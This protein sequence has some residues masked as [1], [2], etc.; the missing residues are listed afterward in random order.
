MKSLSDKKSIIEALD[1][2][3]VFLE[4][5]GENPFKVRAFSNASRALQSSTEDINKLVETDRIIEIK[6]IGKGIADVITEL[7]KTGRSSDLERLKASVPSG[8]IEMLRLPGIGPKKAKALWEKLGISSVGEL[9]YACME[10]RLLDLDGFGKKTQDKILLGIEMLKKYSERHLLSE[11][12]MEAETLFGSIKD[13]PGVIRGQIAGSIRRYMETVK[14][15]DILISAK[16]EDRD[17]IMDKFVSLPQVEVLIAKGNTKS[18]VTLKGGMNADLRIV[19]DQEFPYALHHFTGSKEHNVAMRGYARKG[20][21]KMNEY[22]LFKG[23]SENIECLSESD[24]FD[25]LNMQYIPPELRENYGEIELAQERAIPRLIDIKDIR[26]IIHVHSNYSDGV[27]T[28]SELAKAAQQMGYH[29]LAITDHSR[30]AAYANGLTEERILRQHEEIDRINTE[31]KTFRVLKGIECDIIADGTLD[32]KDHVLASFDL[33]IASVHYKLNMTEGEATG[34]VLAAMQNPYVTILGHPTGRLL[35]ARE[36]YP[37]DMHRVIQSAA[38]LG[39]SIELNSNP[40]RLDIDWRFLGYAKKQGVKISI[41]P[42][43]H[44]IKGIDDIQYG[45]GIARKGRLEER[46]VLNCL[47][48]DEL[49][50]FAYA[51]RGRQV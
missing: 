47:S 33:V 16:D 22:G 28:I 26:G 36:G 7:V 35:L 15:I 10:N 21:I 42:D 13:F 25:R 14:D 2:M 8:M 9:E 40:H 11:A 4:I 5:K 20:N 27:D 17:V 49:I 50:R 24:I 45:V 46:D 43:A 34:R 51:R 19:R 32:Y 31:F 48:A 23:D 3:A 41:N 29:Y 39:T 6:G 37:I 1:Q 18:S 44:R 38:E 30:S 12:K